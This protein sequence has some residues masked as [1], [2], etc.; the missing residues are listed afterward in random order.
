MKWAMLVSML[1][2][3][4]R[5]LRKV[6]KDWVWYGVAVG[7]LSYGDGGGVDISGFLE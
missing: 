4:L 1:E 6:D 3:L 2:V 7:I 5:D